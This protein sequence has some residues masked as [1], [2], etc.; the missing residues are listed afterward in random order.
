MIGTLDISLPYLLFVFF[1]QNG[2]PPF[3]HINSTTDGQKV[4]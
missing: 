4:D 1:V 2:L 3:V